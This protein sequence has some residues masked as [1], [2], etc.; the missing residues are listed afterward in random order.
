MANRYVWWINPLDKNTNET[1]ASIFGEQCE[2][3]TCVRIKTAGGEPRDLWRCSSYETVTRL[4][5]SREQLNLKFTVFRS[6]VLS[7]DSHSP[8]QEFDFRKIQS[9][10]KKSANPLKI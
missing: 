7:D 1:I 2:E 9:R 5:N 3:R 6:Y 4:R 8:P 10:P